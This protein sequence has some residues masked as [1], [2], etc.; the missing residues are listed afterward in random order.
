SSTQANSFDQLDWLPV[1]M[2][3]GSKFVVHIL[4]GALL[5]SLGTVLSLSLQLQ[6]TFL[7]LAAIFMLAT[8][9]NLLSLHPIFRYAA[10]QPPRFLQKFVR[11]TSKSSALFAPAILG[12][13]TVFIPC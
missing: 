6:L 8:A 7:F 3:L 10:L 12:A 9:G 13:V 11:R 4:L 1:A 5:G 2:F